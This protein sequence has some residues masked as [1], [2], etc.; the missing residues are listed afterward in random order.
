MMAIDYACLMSRKQEA[1]VFFVGGKKV[2]G[3]F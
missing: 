2:S 1:G 3:T